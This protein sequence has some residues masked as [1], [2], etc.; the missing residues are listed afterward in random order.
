MAQFSGVSEVTYSFNALGTI[1]HIVT[2]PTQT[3]TKKEKELI[4]ERAQIFGR[5][6]SRFDGTSLLSRLNTEKKLIHPSEEMK[7]M[8]RHALNLYKTTEG[9]FNISI[10]AQLEKDGYGSISDK[11]SVISEHLVEDIYIGKDMIQIAPNIRLDF[12]G[13]GKGWLVDAIHRL[14]IAMNKEDH[15]VNGGGDLR[16]NG[17]AKKIHIE[18]PLHDGY[19]LGNVELHNEAFAVSSNL[20]R[21]WQTKQGTQ[22]A[23]IIQPNGRIN[24]ENIVQVCARAKT[25]LIADSYATILFLQTKAEREGTSKETAIAHAKIFSDGHVEA[26]RDFN[27]RA[28]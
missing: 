11:S 18:N 24:I 27:L 12:G 5:T 7:E 4:A 10:G 16:V 17:S 6:Y 1:W 3:L 8:L 15:I 14:L 20:K 21:T 22:K 13:F 19:S 23:H 28:D 2:P 25:C 26:T 9:L